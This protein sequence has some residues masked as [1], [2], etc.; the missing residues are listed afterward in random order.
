[1]ADAS[2]ILMERE[3]MEKNLFWLALVKEVQDRLE[4]DKSNC[5]DRTK[6]PLE[7]VRLFQGKVQAWKLFFELPDLIMHE[8]ATSEMKG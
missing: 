4:A 8:I 7:E 1:M 6:A 3:K 2:K 5:S